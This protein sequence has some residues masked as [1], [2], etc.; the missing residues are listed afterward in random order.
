MDLI[1][2]VIPCRNERDNLPALFTVFSKLSENFIPILIDN[3]STDG[4][5][6][7]SR[8]YGWITVRETSP[9]YGSACLQGIRYI[10]E[11]FPDVRVVAFYEAEVNENLLELQR[12]VPLVVR[13]EVD[14]VIGARPLRNMTPHV[15]VANGIFA[16]ILR[17][18]FRFNGSDNGPMRVIS[19]AT[20]LS[21][22]M[23]DRTFG[24]TF[25]MTIKALKKN[26][27]VAV[28]PVSHYSRYSGKSK[29]SGSLTNSFRAVGRIL[30]YCLRYAI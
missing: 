11:N 15:R 12:M 4:S 21:L 6:D 8:S 17:V 1:P 26:Y 16:L 14:L 20:L 18:L 2:I 29:I 3:G 10:S 23:K 28:V 19:I 7:L 9:G 30:Y 24:W 27:R 25:E 5:G 22:G 13:G